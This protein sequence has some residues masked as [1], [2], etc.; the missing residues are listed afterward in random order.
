MFKHLLIATD[1]S[2]PTAKAET[3]GLTLT[4]RIGARVTVVTATEPSW[5]RRKPKAATWS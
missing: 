3:T 2:E 4:K 1:R 5:K